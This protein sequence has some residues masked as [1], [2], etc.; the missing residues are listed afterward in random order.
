MFRDPFGYS[1]I[2]NAIEKKIIKIDFVNIRDFGI[3]KHKMVDDKPYGGGKGMI[4]R[5]DVL[6]SA[7]KKAKKMHKI[8]RKYQKIV[9]LDPIGKTF[10]Q[11]QAVR[12]SKIKHLILICGHY[13]G[14]DARI[15][16]YV[17]EIISI[18]DFILT[19]GE[20]PAMLI[21]DS[22]TRLIKG[23]L[24]ENATAEE[25]FSK[26]ENQIFLEYPQ[27]TRPKIYKKDKVPEILF[28]GDHQKI[29]AWRK[30]SAEEITSKNRPDLLRI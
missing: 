29:S 4:L 15:K 23:V 3:G 11:K 13:E 7:I 1:I 20:I 26:K 22:V 21:V 19:G 18:G 2:K 27:Y 5:V 6:H 8:E 28:S 17:D 14:F 16:N 24:P 12:L 25:S 30:K 10:N 9:L